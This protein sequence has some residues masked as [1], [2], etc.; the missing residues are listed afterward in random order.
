MAINTDIETVESLGQ[1]FDEFARV[2]E[3]SKGNLE[4]FV[5]GVGKIWEAEA[6]N[7]F[8]RDTLAHTVEL[9]RTIQQMRQIAEELQTKANYMR[10]AWSA[11]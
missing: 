8:R 2:L 6:Y 4:S 1:N 9:S 10:R 7:K 5:D 11:E 3:Y